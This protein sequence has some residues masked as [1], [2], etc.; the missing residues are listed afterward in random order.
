MLTA[1]IT[2]RRRK[3]SNPKIVR[4]TKSNQTVILP[5]LISLSSFEHGNVIN[6]TLIISEMQIN[7]LNVPRKR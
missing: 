3:S 6:I 7:F 5:E 2:I 4:E 1:K